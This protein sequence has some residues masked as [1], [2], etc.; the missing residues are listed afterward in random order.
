M[1]L[2]S[3]ALRLLDAIETAEMRSLEWGFVDGSLSETEIS[4]LLS[5]GDVEEAFEELV[6]A[7]AIIETTNASGGVRIRSRFA[8]TMR[9]LVSNRQQFPG[10]PWQGASQ[11]VSDFRVDRRKRRFPR[12]DLTPDAILEAH[13]ALL[14]PTTLRTALWTSLTSRPEMRL[15]GFQERA[16]V[17][18]AAPID[19]GGTIITAGT[20]SGK[21]IAFY[22]PAMI[23]IGEAVDQDRWVKAIAVY[24]RIELLKDQFAEAFRMSRSIDGA[25]SNAG[26]RPLVLGALFGSTP[27]QAT[28]ASISDKGWVKRGSDFICPWM[29]CPPVTASCFGQKRTSRRVGSDWSAPGHAATAASPRVT[30]S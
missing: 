1:T 26:R 30:L 28:V 22:I 6:E 13:G 2:S 17:R 25:L 14:A 9:L 29:R 21:T 5:D 10:K 8:E 27:T 12:R 15:A 7:R 23:R 3:Q 18:L 11:L 19:D 4:R 16:A 24:P 20:G